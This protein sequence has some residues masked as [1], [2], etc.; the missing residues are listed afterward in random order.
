MT[1]YENVKHY[2]KNQCIELATMK[3]IRNY[4][5]HINGYDETITLYNEDDYIAEYLIDLALSALNDDRFFNAS[6]YTKML[7]EYFNDYCR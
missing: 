3:E 6:C 7:A 5:N 1:N 2:L 4:V